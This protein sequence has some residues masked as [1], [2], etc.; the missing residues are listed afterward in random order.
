MFTKEEENLFHRLASNPSGYPFVLTNNELDT[1]MQAVKRERARAEEDVR[2]IIRHHIAN[3]FHWHFSMDGGFMPD[4]GEPGYSN[5]YYQ[6]STDPFG[7]V[8]KSFEDLVLWL[9]HYC[10]WSMEDVDKAVA[11]GANGG[12]TTVRAEEKGII[13]PYPPTSIEKAGH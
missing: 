12:K 7:L 3:K 11:Y 10:S 6:S 5:K 8:Y 9:V 13:I 4:K 1:L 2:R